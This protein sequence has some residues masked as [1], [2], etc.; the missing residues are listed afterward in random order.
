MASDPAYAP[1]PVPV[2][3]GD[4][5]SLTPEQMRK[6]AEKSRKWERVAVLTVVA[7]MMGGCANMVA[8]VAHEYAA[9]RI[10]EAK[11]REARP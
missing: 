3:A 1:Q 8:S 11:A 7:T 10:A 9:I 6:V 2:I 5:D 4:G